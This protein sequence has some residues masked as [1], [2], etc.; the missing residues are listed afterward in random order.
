[1]TSTELDLSGNTETGIEVQGKF[2]GTDLTYSDESYDKP[3]VRVPNAQKDTAKVTIK[4][5]SGYKVDNSTNYFKVIKHDTSWC[6][7]KEQKHEGKNLEN[8]PNI[9]W[10]DIVVE[11]HRNDKY[12]YLLKEHKKEYYFILFKDGSAVTIVRLVEKGKSIDLPSD[13]SNDEYSKKYSSKNNN[14]IFKGWTKSGSS[15]VI[16]D[17]KNEIA[18]TSSKLYFSV[19]E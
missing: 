16:T 10:S 8:C 6:N 13:F 14:K 1:M 12:Y 11:E 9:E 18:D 17:W 7:C 3:V 19:W 5:K 2:D 4:D 15:Q